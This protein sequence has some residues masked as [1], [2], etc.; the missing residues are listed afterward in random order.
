MKQKTHYLNYLRRYIT[1]IDETRTSDLSNKRQG[2]PV[3]T[4]KYINYLRKYLK[5]L[6]I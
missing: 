5:I 1:Q 2:F 6:E 3:L 4:D